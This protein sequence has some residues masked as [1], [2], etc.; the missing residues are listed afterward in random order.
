MFR[1][2]ACSGDN[3]SSVGQHCEEPLSTEGGSLIG[4]EL[5]VVGATGHGAAG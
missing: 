4:S 1:F 3:R 2:S 5:V